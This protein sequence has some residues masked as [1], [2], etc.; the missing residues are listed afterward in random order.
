M[1]SPLLLLMILYSVPPSEMKVHCWFRPPFAYHW[2]IPVYGAWEAPGTSSSRPKLEF[3]EMWMV[4]LASAWAVPAPP[5][6]RTVARVTAAAV[7]AR[8]RGRRGLVERR[9]V[10]L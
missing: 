5:T 2:M 6:A 8:R 9:A 1:R 3:G 10:V 7:P 4:K